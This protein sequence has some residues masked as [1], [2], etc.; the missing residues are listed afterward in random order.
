MCL[1]REGLSCI[2]STETAPRKDRWV[3]HPKAAK[4]SFLLVSWIPFCV[5]PWLSS[6]FNFCFPTSSHARKPQILGLLLPPIFSSEYDTRE[7]Q[8][9]TQNTS[10]NVPDMYAEK[11]P[12]TVPASGTSLQ[13]DR[14]SHGVLLDHEPSVITIGFA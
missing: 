13:R 7:I 6:P 1:G 14:T 4:W 11:G 10:V 2:D 5:L 9:S 12:G 8:H 3:G